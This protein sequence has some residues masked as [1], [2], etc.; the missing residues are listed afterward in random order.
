M[1]SVARLLIYSHDSF[2]LGHLRRCRA[3]AHHLVERYRQLSILILTGSPIIGSFDFKTRVDFVRIPGV[4]KLRSG[5]YT[6]LSLHLDI[7]QTLAMRSSIIKHTAEIFDPHLFLVD[8]E[9]LG[10]RGEVGDT[11]EMLK[12]RGTRLILGLRDVMDEPKLLQK[13]WQRK[14]VY[15]ALNDLYDEIWIYGLPEIFDPV[16]E[17]PNM[18]HLAEK[19]TFTGYLR[20]QL[21]KAPPDAHESELPNEPY[22]LVTTGG[23]GDGEDLIDWVLSAY[24]NHPDM[25]HPALL[26]FGP[27][28][29][30]DLR[31]AFQERVAKLAKVHAITFEARFERLVDRAIGVVAMGGY[32]T[33]CEILSFGKPALIVPRTKPRQEQ[34]LRSKRAEALGLVCVLADDGKRDP[35]VMA[36]E[37]RALPDWRPNEDVDMTGFLGG[38]DKIAE[39][40]R[41]WLPVRTREATNGKLQRTA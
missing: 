37:L 9:P 20:R 29:K 1:S 5:N 34:L 3:I 39:L 33:F 41:S 16:S 14:N 18:Q 23:G 11:L 31:L 17:L 24:E 4:I 8:K 6:P 25:P 35:K 22:L 15:P 38:L 2:G 28:M 40:V 19:M 7:E 32:N 26:V 10:L 12:D 27:F 30:Q 13:E 21:P 36:A